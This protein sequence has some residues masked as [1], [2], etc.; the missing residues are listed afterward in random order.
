M[1][2]RPALVKRPPAHPAEPPAEPVSTPAAEPPAPARAAAAAGGEVLLAVRLP[3]ELRRWYRQAA[4]DH[5]RPMRQLV[6]EALEEYR[7]KLTR[8]HA[9]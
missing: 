2:D 8:E 9:G 5:E 1:P 7:T 4:L 6:I 3:A